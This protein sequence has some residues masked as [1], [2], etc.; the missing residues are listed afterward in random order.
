MV[1]FGTGQFVNNCR[2]GQ[3]E[4][5]MTRGKYRSNKPGVCSYRVERCGFDW[6]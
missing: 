6:Q 3:R 4:S 1:T 5:L 2:K